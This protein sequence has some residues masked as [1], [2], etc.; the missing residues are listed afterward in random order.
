MTVHVLT[1]AA[2]SPG[3][4]TT[5]VGLALSWPRSVLLVDHDHQ[6]AVLTGYLQASQPAMSGHGILHVLDAASRQTS[7]R[8]AVWDQTVPLPEDRPDRRRLLLPGLP[9]PSS[10][11]GFLNGLW[12]RLGQALA[13]LGDAGVDVIV[14]AGRY[15][16]R[17][18]WPRELLIRAD[19]LLLM[20]P[21]TLAAATAAMPVANALREAANAE[22]ASEAVQVLVRRPTGPNQSGRGP[23]HL[24]QRYY[25]DR[26]VAEALGVVVAGTVEA[27]PAAA[28]YL[29]EGEPRPAKW[30]TGRY[31]RSL[32]VLATRLAQSSYRRKAA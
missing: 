31:A 24:Q 23:L 25:A 13:D 11:V 14:D 2:G 26:E 3:V 28:S 12:G 8:N 7:L 10:T 18:P 17:E 20:V 29:S 21:P 4:T 15:Q 19:R 9:G 30:A 1:S 27:D 32:N 6:Q 22:G 16:V 5:A